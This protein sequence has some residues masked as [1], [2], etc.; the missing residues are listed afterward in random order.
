MTKKPIANLGGFMQFDSEKR[1]YKV[2]GLGLAIVEL[3][4]KLYN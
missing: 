3:I 1:D 4:T 2:L